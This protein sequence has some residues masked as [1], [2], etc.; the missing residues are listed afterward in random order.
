MTQ[1]RKLRYE[2][3]W[4]AINVDAFEEAI[5]WSPEYTKGS[6]DVGFCV[7]PQNHAHGDTTG[8]FAIERDE[9][10]YNCWACGG[11]SLL[12]LAMELYSFDVD[13]ATD[14]LYQFTEADARSD[15]EFVDDFLDAFRD[16]EKRTASLPYFNDRVLERFNEPVPEAWLEARGISTA[17]ATAYGL[18]YSS[19]IKRN[20][21][22]RGAFADD[23]PYYGSGIIFPHYWNDRLV[24]WQTRWLDDYRPDWVPKYTMT[25]DFPKETTI[26]GWDYVQKDASVAV[27]ESVPTALLFAS[28]SYPSVAT[29]GSNVNEAQMR[30]LRRFPIIYLGADN[31]KPSKAGGRPAG[32]KW[33]DSLTQY[34]SKY[35]T[36][37]W[38][39]LTPEQ[40]TDHGDLRGGQQLD[41]YMEGAYEPGLEMERCTHCGWKDCLS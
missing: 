15:S 14:W 13:E 2:D 10:V 17:T 18:R 37:Y 23:E 28:E 8:K 32:L 30:L 40:G 41:D 19:D 1:Q 20:P 31:D 25:S 22:M 6:N 12:S 24:G 26:Y 9:R 35:S 36:V 33:R 27:F 34:L 4:D 21:P 16:V 5:G 11:G 29:F 7:F 38:L 3:F 39:P